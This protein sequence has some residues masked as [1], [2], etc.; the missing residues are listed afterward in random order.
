MGLSTVVNV[1]PIDSTNAVATG[2]FVLSTNQVTPVVRALTAHGVTVTAVHSHL[3][4]SAPELLFVHF[5]GKDT[6]AHITEALAAAVA[7]E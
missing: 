2:D 1:Q 5:W 3:M 4:G 7:A 6:A